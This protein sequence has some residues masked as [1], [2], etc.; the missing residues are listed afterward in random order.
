VVCYC[1]DNGTDCERYQHITDS[2]SDCETVTCFISR[3]KAQ[4]M[5]C[6]FKTKGSCDT[7]DC[8][9]SYA[10]DMIRS[11]LIADIRN[12]TH[13]TKVLTEIAILKTLD[14]L[15]SRLLAL[16]ATDC[17]SSQF[18]SPFESAS[19]DVTPIKSQPPKPQSTA[20]KQ[21][22]GC[23]KAIHQNGRQSCPARQ[24][25]CHKCKKPNHFA[26]VCRSSSVSTIS[27]KPEPNVSYLSSI[28]AEPI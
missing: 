23:G 3:L 21:C 4:A 27:E 1:R 9:S 16:E 11:Q 2:Q 10:P 14:D 13:Q 7:P 17:A 18:R 5:L 26:T 19:S 12:P 22:S 20:K 6:D 8:A 24:K 28:N 25:V 15:T